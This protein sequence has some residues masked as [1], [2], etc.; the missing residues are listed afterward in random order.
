MNAAY[1]KKYMSIAGY[2]GRG[3]LSF[4][5]HWWYLNGTGAR[6]AATAYIY[7]RYKAT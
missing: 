6:K 4:E 7:V 5:K 2:E 3:H 1:N